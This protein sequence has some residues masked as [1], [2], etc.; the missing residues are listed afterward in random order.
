[1]GRGRKYSED[2]LMGILT[3]YI[4]DEDNRYKTKIKYSELAKYAQAMGYTDIANTD[5]NRAPKIV[6]VVNKYNGAKAESAISRNGGDK[7]YYYDFDIPSII[8]KNI[9]KPIQLQAQIQIFKESYKRCWDELQALLN[10]IKSLE[11]ENKKLQNDLKELTESNK[12]YKSANLDLKKQSIS[13]KNNIKYQCI[14]EGIKYLSSTNSITITNEEDIVNAVMNFRDSRDYKGDTVAIN[15]LL[16]DV[17]I[18]EVE[19]DNN[20]DYLNKNSNVMDDYTTKNSKII[21]ITDRKPTLN[22]PDF[23]K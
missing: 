18:E 2:A 4:N 14:L 23:M 9:K 16:E 11:D 19:L 17:S 1:M 8:E 6:E 21:D 13:H 7:I 15:E 22:I 5:F 3:T 10:Q 20:T 12:L